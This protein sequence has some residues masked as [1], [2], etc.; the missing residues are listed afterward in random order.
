MKK[1]LALVLS[2]ILL[3]SM[4]SAALAEDVTIG[5][6]SWALAEEKLIPVYGGSANAFMEDNPGIIIDY[7]QSNPYAS[8][9]DQLL[10]AAS[11]GNAPYVAHIKA[12]WLPQ[13]LELG[14]L[15]DLTPYLNADVIADYSPG[16]IA[17][18]TIDGKIIAMPWFGNTIAVYYNKAL[19]AQAG[20]ETLPQTWDELVAD[21]YQIAALGE[22]IYGLAFPNSNGVEA[23]EGYNVFPALW[24][25][26]GDFLD[27]EGKVNL[28]DEAAIKTFTEIQKLVLDK[29][30]P[31]V[32]NS[33]KDLRN[34]FGQGKIGFYW[35]LEATVATAAA[36]APDE[37]KFYEDFGCFVIPG[38]D[39]PN[40][41]GYVIDHYLVVMNNCPDEI[42]PQVATFLEYMS[43]ARV[44]Q[45]F[46]D[47]NQGKMSSRASVME[48][49]FAD[50][51]DITK[52]Y[53]EAMKTARPLPV[54]GLHFMDAD[55]ELVNAMTRLAQ[56]EDVTAVMTDCQSI[57]Q[58]MY[59]EE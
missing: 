31:T 11:A 53:V 49:V 54:S 36:A 4:S 52:V 41:S 48:K 27:A 29:V 15:K 28:T 44:I 33:L 32:G 56:G 42:M 17:G 40:G 13:F 51:G 37:A 8:Y 21:A 39:T 9:L 47:G 16:A 35:D 59:D 7:S 55:K 2:V 58:E 38:G 34:L 25:N 50:V 22:D 10:T 23:G 12:E 46:K 57:I 20:I 6:T 1:C 26:G 30:S 19:L 5:W 14:A 43:D 3:A 18:A 45:I 24:A